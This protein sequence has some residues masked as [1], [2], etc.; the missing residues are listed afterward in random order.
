MAAIRHSYSSAK[1]VKP[2]AAHRTAGVSLALVFLVSLVIPIQTSIGPLLIPPYRFVLLLLTLPCL[3]ML[4]AGTKGHIRWADIFMLL[5][6]VWA[7]LALTMNHGIA[8]GIESGGVY[9][10]ESFGA[11]AIARCFIRNTHDFVRTFRFLLIIVAIFIP[12]GFYEFIT[13]QSLGNK[14]FSVV[15]P[16]ITPPQMES[17]MGLYRASGSFAHPILFGVFCASVLGLA[18]ATARRG[19]RLWG[20]AIPSVAGFFSLSAGPLI[21][22][23]FQ[24]GMIA[25]DRLARRIPMRWWLMA[26]MVV[27]GY[28]VIDLL[29]DKSPIELVIIYLT[30][31]TGSAWMRMHIWDYGTAEVLRHPLFGIGMHE[32]QNPTW[33]SQSVDN[34]WLFTAM[35]YGLPAFVLLAMTFLTVL[36]GLLR[37]HIEPAVATYRFGWIVSIGGLSL[38]A[39]TV[40]YWQNSFSLFMFILGSGVWMLDN[41]GQKHGQR[42]RPP[43]TQIMP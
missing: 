9:F 3:G 38:A 17:R 15:F 34:F 16:V 35:R 13:G 39:A 37:K 36:V 4:L 18:Y 29:S 32:W 5:H 20:I 42:R 24:I 30:F 12:I 1:V 26:G 14:I 21:A 11:Y 31:N 2:R 6:A 28:I 8:T 40:H 10:I 27:S 43:N 22:V 33:M 41:G 23:A 19:R 7:I 25:W